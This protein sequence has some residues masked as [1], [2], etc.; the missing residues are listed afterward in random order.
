MWSTEGHYYKASWVRD[1]IL[2]T[3]NLIW[4]DCLTKL[5]GI[6]NRFYIC[7]WNKHALN[8]S[9]KRQHLRSDTSW[10]RYLRHILW[11]GCFWFTHFYYRWWNRHVVK[12]LTSNLRN[13]YNW[14][15]SCDPFCDRIWYWHWSY[16]NLRWCYVWGTL[17]WFFW[18]QILHHR[19]S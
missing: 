10:F 14:A 9:G 5:T 7:H 17:H 1:L 4:Y 3:L 16:S 19:L 2:A 12:A 13:W 18:H 6:Y 15:V 8:Y 11:R